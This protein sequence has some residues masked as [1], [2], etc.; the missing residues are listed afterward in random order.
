MLVDEYQDTNH[1]QYVLIRELVGGQP[2]EPGRRRRL[3]AARRA[4]RGRRRRPVD[5][6]V[7]RRDDTQHHRVRARFPRRPGDP[8]RAELPL[9]AEHPG[10]RQRGRRPQLRPDAEEPVVGRGRRAAD[11]RLRRG[12]RARRGRVRGRGGGQARRRGRRHRRRRGRVLPD[13]RA[14]QGLR[15]SVHQGRAAV[16]GS[17]RRAVLRAARGQGPARV[18]AA[19]RQPRRRDLAAP[20]SSTS[21][22][23]ASATGRWSTRPGSPR[24]SGSPS[25]PRSR[26]RGRRRAAGPLGQGHRGIQRTDRR[27]AA[28]R[29]VGHSGRRHRRGRCSTGPAISPSSRRRPT[30]RTRAGRRT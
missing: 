28:G 16:Q 2:G 10:R 22:G 14:V 23:A 21:R 6:R 24:A 5:L 17:R 1:A 27:T 15:G 30:C 26:G 18:P 8:A 9:H 12:Q 11:S 19:D 29:R 20:R 4:V 25:P 13:Q 3:P 7:P